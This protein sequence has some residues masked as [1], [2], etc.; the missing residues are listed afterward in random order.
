MD[1]TLDRNETNEASIKIKIDEAD[2]Q[3][4]VDEKLKE[5]KKKANI[6]GFRPGKVPTTLLKKMYGKAILVDELN[7][8]LQHSLTNYIKEQ[9]LNII[10]EPLPN[11]DKNADVDFD[12]QKNFEFEY[13]IG[14]VDDFEV[15]LDKKFTYYEIKVDKK[16]INKQA[17][18][19]QN[20]Y[21]P[22]KEV[23][24]IDEED[25][26]R[27]ELKQEE[28]DINKEAILTLDMI[29][30]G[31]KK[32]FTGKK[33]GD[34]ISFEIEKALT[35]AKAISR[36]TDKPE[37]E[38]NEV[39]GTFTFTVTKIER[40]EKADLNQE[41]FDKLFGPDQVKSEE[42]FK[43]KLEESF[44]ENYQRESDQLFEIEARET[45]VDSTKIVVPD[46][47]FKKWLIAANKEEIDEATV[48]KDYEKY[49][50]ELKWMLIKSKILSQFDL[51]IEYNEVEDK[52]KELFRNY[53]QSS[54]LSSDQM[55]ASLGNFAQNYLQAENGK[56][57]MNLQEQIK[58]EKVF[59]TIKE[60]GSVKNKQ[61][62]FDEFKKIV[63]NK[64]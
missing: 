7:H 44:K 49:V 56:N 52:A 14:L 41:F 27:G 17:E 55:E 8:I 20:Q 25:M 28:G 36:L 10:G 37:E 45:L 22:L 51:K 61:V 50:N 40:R 15:N 9:D 16:E 38:A 63:E 26:V 6:K 39:K 58:N 11:N 5:Y 35:D 54:G 12:T 3:P 31:E 18:E 2:Y 60:H 47:F 64:A 46:N 53:L 30:K 13:E 59:A 29:N 21:G 32:K 24:S 48:E 4:K 1:I 42:E 34:S 23:E 43:N 62:A 57:Y 33:L 19:L